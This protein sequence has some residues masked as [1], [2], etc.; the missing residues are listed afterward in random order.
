MATQQELLQALR[1]A[2]AAGDTAAATRIAQLLKPGPE[3]RAVPDDTE[4]IPFEEP[5]WPKNQRELYPIGP[6]PEQFKERAGIILATA[7]S[8]AAPQ[9]AI[10]SK[11]FQGAA[12][13]SGAGLGGA[14]GEM[15]AGS[16]QNPLEPALKY[17][18]AETAGQGVGKVIG[19][20]LT[21]VTKE[22][23]DFFKKA[24][25]LFDFA[26][27]ND[28]PI[29]SGALVPGMTQKIIQGGTDNFLPSRL[30]NDAYR[31]K[32]VT[33]MNELMGE[34]PQKSGPVLGKEEAAEITMEAFQ[35]ASQAKLQMG[36]KLINEAIDSLPTGRETPIPIPNTKSTLEKILKESKDKTL[37]NFAELELANTDKSFRRAESLDAVKRQMRAALRNVKGT[38]KKFISELRTAVDED[39]KAAGADLEKMKAADT[40]FKMNGELMDSP[41]ARRLLSGNMTPAALT[42]SIFKAGNERFVKKLAKELPE[43]T[44]DS[45]KAQNLANLF[46]NF[47]EASDRLPGARVLTKGDQLVKWIESN[48]SVLEAAYDK[49]TIEALT[50]FAELA[51]AS[52]KDLAEF[53]KGGFDMGT[54]TTTGA[55][56]GLGFGGIAEP[57]TLVFGGGMS[58]PIATE[59][60]RPGGLLKTWLVKGWPKTKAAVNAGKSA[61][62]ENL[63]EAEQFLIE[64]QK[65]GFREKA[66]EAQGGLQ[67][68]MR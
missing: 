13:I 40:F 16:P 55:M 41:V 34:L 46:E 36:K 26:K 8:I 37:R 59:M 57:T 65:L 18:A 9:F 22:A 53:K 27:K 32:M 42:P 63:P 44:W 11:L 45:L 23:T 15:L 39:F 38:D 24:Q 21:P 10:P 52:S 61:L 30:V 68:L 49:E 35:A 20:V 4:I 12:A 5:E 64:A 28:I 58:L 51:K 47:S 67:G 66:D 17:G 3:F 33:R 50:N 7:G 60:M 6:S 19:D 56:G 48:K 54:L 2:D 31:G 43:E 29:S 25:S 62:R 1:N 14:T